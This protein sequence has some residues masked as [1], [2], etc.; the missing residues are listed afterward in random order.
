VSSFNNG[1]TK[2]VSLD[3]GVGQKG[4]RR[5]HDPNVTSGVTNLLK[6]R[7]E[8][9]FQREAHEEGGNACPYFPRVKKVGGGGKG[10]LVPN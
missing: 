6:R 5:L 4:R 1:I 8:K 9:I 7:K 3:E 10:G 2:D